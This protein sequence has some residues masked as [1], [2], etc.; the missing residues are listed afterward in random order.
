MNPTFSRTNAPAVSDILSRADCEALAKR[1][2]A[3]AKADETRVTIGSDMRSD[4]RFAVNQI[5]T[6]GEDV[7]T[8]ITIQSAFGKRSASVTTN[9]L[10]DASISAAVR[11]AETLAHLS[12]ESP[13]SMP[14]LGPQTYQAAAPRRL[15]SMPS[16]TDRASAIGALTA[17]ARK[18]GCISTGYIETQL[19]AT[20]IA[21]SRG[22]FAYD[23]SSGT[24][25]TMTVRTPDGTGSGWAG[26]DVETWPEIDAA[27]LGAHATEKALKS[28]HP[29]AVEP[30]RYTVVLEPAAVGSLVSLVTDELSAREADEGRSYFA[31]PGGGNKLGERLFGDSVTLISDPADQS[32]S[33]FSD[34]GL[35]SRRVVWVE[36]GILKTLDYGR[37]WAQKSGVQP[38]AAP[39]ALRMLGGTM[40]LPSMIASTQQ[41]LL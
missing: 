8:S 41:G 38:T 11:E 6:S 28:R 2:L 14:E 17:H 25:M 1:V 3:F 22:L 18:A 12:P 20:A 31:R 29:V 40:S 30:G 33:L 37:F 23:Q 16:A 15:A 5:S 10:D 26:V 36:R 4:T 21:N 32:G 34:D 13:E 9:K 35:P 39:G 7:N 19:G 27:Q 24:T